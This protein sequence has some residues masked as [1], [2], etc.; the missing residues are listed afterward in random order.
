MHETK[1][2][3]VV[4]FHEQFSGEQMTAAEAAE[5]LKLL[6]ETHLVRKLLSATIRKL[7][8]RAMVPTPVAPPLHRH[9]HLFE[10][11]TGLDVVKSCA[12]WQKCDKLTC[13]NFE[14]IKYQY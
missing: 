9:Y 8:H 7:T 13:N 2:A 6:I 5:K 4:E 1:K 11:Q 10:Q 14:F 12:R 3:A